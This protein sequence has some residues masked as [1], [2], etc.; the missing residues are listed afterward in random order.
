MDDFEKR[1]Q[2]IREQ[3]GAEANGSAVPRVAST[4]TLFGIKSSVEQR[5]DGIAR[6]IEEENR[7]KRVERRE[8]ERL[9]RRG[10]PDAGKTSGGDGEG[11]CD[12]G[13]GCSGEGN[14]PA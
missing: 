2:R 1:W 5:M 14:A 9:G 8:R 11:G 10:D 7:R 12:D 3:L 6:E 4:Q 13:R